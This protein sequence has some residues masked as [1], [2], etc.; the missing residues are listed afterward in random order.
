MFDWPGLYKLLLAAWWLNDV[1][2]GFSSGAKLVLV[3][4]GIVLDRYIALTICFSEHVYSSIGLYNY[5]FIIDLI[6]CFTCIYGLLGDYHYYITVNPTRN[7]TVF[8]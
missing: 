8:V 2:F 4:V 7:A 5:V 6:L 1:V 3:C